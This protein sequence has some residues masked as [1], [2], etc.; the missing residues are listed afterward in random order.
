MN[1]VILG[2]GYVG[3]A[4]A[5]YWTQT[6]GLTV[7]ATTTTPSKIQTLTP[8]AHQVK[9]IRGNDAEGLKSIL[10]GQEVILLTVAAQGRIRDAQ[11]YREAYLET[12]RTLASILPGLPAVQQLIYTSTYPVYGDQKGAVVD[13]SSPVYPASENSK[14]LVETEETLLSLANDRFKVCILRLGGIYGPGREVAKIFSRIAGKTRPGKGH[15]PTHW[16]HL[17]DIVGVIEFIRK[18]QLNG[19]YNLVDQSNYTT[20]EL[21]DLVCEKHG[22]DPIIWDESQPDQRTYNVTVSNQKILQA[23]YQFIHPQTL[24]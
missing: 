8:I 6:L 11:A 12:A 3:S 7:T 4:V 18:N 20:R 2:C 19:L 1:V 22:L 21:I 23:G 5:R 9:V 15:S 24:I 14:I 16:V 13:E 10:D 17:D